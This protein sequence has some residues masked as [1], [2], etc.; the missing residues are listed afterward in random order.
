VDL[1]TGKVRVMGKGSKERFVYL[2]KRA[3]SAL[4][5]YVHDER[6]EHAQANDE[7]LFLTQDGYPMTRYTVGSLIA[8]ASER[9]GFHAH[10]H[11]LRH[12]AAI[13]RLRNGMDLISLQ[14][15]LGHETLEVTRAYLTAL[16]DEDVEQAATRTSPADSWRL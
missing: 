11:Q 7:H 12:T 9:A 15:M 10:P 14:R 4:W 5:L 3:L 1:K 8:R 16:N 2:G 13:A 6:P